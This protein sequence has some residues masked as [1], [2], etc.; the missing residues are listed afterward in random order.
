M[1]ELFGKFKDVVPYLFFGVCT[2][3]VNIVVYWLSVHILSQSV[4]TGTIIAWIAAVLFAYL[5]NRKWVF[6]SKASTNRDII[7]EMSSFFG[8]RLA[9]GVLDWLLMFFFVDC[10]K[11]NDIVIK[12]ISNVVVIVLNYIA[13][14]FVIFRNGG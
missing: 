14:K 10:L 7:K 2:T 9:S 8:C 4:M 11:C 13:S 6:H 5:T 1:Q 3:L 12:T